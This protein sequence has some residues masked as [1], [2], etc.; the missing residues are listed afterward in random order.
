MVYKMVNNGGVTLYATNNIQKK[1]FEL[2]GYTVAETY[3]VVSL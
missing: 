3:K 2:Y 1:A